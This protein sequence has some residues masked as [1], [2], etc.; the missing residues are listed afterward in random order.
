MVTLVMVVV[1]SLLG[2]GHGGPRTFHTDMIEAGVYDSWEDC[3][4]VMVMHGPYKHGVVVIDG[5]DVFYTAK[6]ICAILGLD[7]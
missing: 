1:S 7:S 2:D 3:E 4:R 5:Q 6:P